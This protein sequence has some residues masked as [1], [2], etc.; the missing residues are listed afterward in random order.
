MLAEKV[1]TREQLE[2]ALKA[3]FDYFQGYF[4]RRPEVLKAREIQVNYLRMPQAVSREEI[5]IRGLESIIKN[6]SIRPVPAFALLE[7]ALI[8]QAQRDSLDPA[9]PGNSGRARDSRWIRLVALVSAGQ[10]KTSDLVLSALVRA[11]FCEL[12]SRRIR[13]TQSD[14]FLVGM[15]SMMDA[16]LD[17]PMT[18]VV[19]KTAIDQ[20]TKC[21]LL[22]Q[23]GRLQAIY[24][25]ML[26]Q[27]AGNWAAAQRFASELRVS[28]SELGELWWQAM[29]WAR[30][31]SSGKE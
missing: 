8:R 12:L 5:D 19:E 20:D 2:T 17:I 26:A 6:G 16:I 25:L 15:V 4:F 31:V 13:R 24:E 14:L 21:V 1:E 30:Q 11:R 29:P 7:F 18:E 3:G 10:Q 28:E 22:G 9:H 23:G 27:E